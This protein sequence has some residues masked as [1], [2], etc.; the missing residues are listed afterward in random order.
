[1][2]KSILKAVFTAIFLIPIFVGCQKEVFNEKAPAEKTTLRISVST[3]DTKVVSGVDDAV[4]NDYQVFLFKEDYSLEDYVNQSSP[5]ITLDCVM[6][7]KYLIVL[8][9]A[10]FMGDVVD[11]ETL[12]TKKSLLSDN[13]ADSIVMEGQNTIE[14]LTQN[15]ATIKVP[16]VRKVAKVELSSLTVDIDMPQYKTKSFKVSSVYLINVSSEMPYFATSDT[17]PLSWSNKLA[18]EPEDVNTLIYDDMDGFEVT[19]NTPYTVKN[20]FYCY[21]NNTGEDTFSETWSPRCTRLVVEAMLGEELYY[22][23][24]TLPKLEQNKI[25]GVNLTITRPGS[26]TPDSLIDMFETNFQVSVKDWVRGTT[27]N[28]QI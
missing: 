16:V 15:P 28:E 20:T 14:I 23:P 19:E 1:M 4:I 6:G 13:E 10:P 3:D 5:D 27:V 18:Y 7:K 26:K 22:Y 11:Y 21:P 17:A 25:Y 2:I 24:V 8:V 12:M 9:N